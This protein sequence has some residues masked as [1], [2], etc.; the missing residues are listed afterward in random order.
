MSHY[1][2]YQFS[3]N[4]MLRSLLLWSCYVILIEHQLC[5]GPKIAPKPQNAQILNNFIIISGFNSNNFN[6]KY[7]RLKLNRIPFYHVDM[8]GDY[9]INNRK[10]ECIEIL[11]Y[12]WV[13]S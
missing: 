11:Y 10:L 3:E 9:I 6:S 1:V 12:I 5:F 13:I 8:I 7:D 4:L 2:F